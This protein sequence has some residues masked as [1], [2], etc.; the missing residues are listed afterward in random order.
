MGLFFDDPLHEMF[1]ATI[2]LG[3]T[4]HEGAEPGEIMAT[5]ARIIDGD[6]DSWYRNGA[7]RRHAWASSVTTPPPAA[8]VSARARRTSAPRRTTR[9]A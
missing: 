8:M 9:L 2:A 3:Q 4:S 1:A 7:L 5:C 6:D